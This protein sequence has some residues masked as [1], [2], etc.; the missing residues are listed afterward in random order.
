MEVREESTETFTVVAVGGRM[1]AEAAREFAE[2]L[3]ALIRGGHERVLI[4]ASKLDYIGSLGLRALLIA[5]QQASDVQGWLALCSLTGPVRRVI[6][7]SGFSS[8]LRT[9][10]SR[11]EA[12]ATLAS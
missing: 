8:I 4:E 1:D 2:R 6:D 7:L 11:D 3:A 9:Y 12:V 10:A 5:A